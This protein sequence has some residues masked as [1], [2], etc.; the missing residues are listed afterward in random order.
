[1]PK[2]NLIWLALAVVIGALL[3]K[4]PEFIVQQEQLYNRFGPMLDVHAQIRKNYVEEVPDNTLIRGAIDGM[5]GRLDPYSH[6]FDQAELDQFNIRTRGEFKGI[7]IEIVQSETGEPL[8]VSPIEGSPAFEAGLRSGDLITRIDSQPTVEL[9]LAACVRLIQGE[10]GTSVTLGIQRPET[11][12]AFEKSITRGIVKVRTVRG[13]ARDA[14]YDWDYLIDPDRRI[15]YVR[16]TSFE[17]VTPEQFDEVMGALLNRQRMRGLVLDLRDNPGGLLDAVVAIANRFLNDGPIVTIRY[18][19]RPEQPYQANGEHTC[20]DF[21]LVILVNKG[22]ASASEILSGALRDRGRAVLVG[23]R[24]F[25]KGSVQEL[26]DIKGSGGLEGAVKLTIAYYYLP[27]GQ[28][29]HG[30]GVAPDKVVPLSAEQQ[31]TMNESWRQVYVTEGLPSAS[32]PATT[33]APRRRTIMIDPQLQVALDILHEQL[34]T[35]ARPRE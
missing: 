17:Q 32:G 34:D 24:T 4:V 31:E 28:R 23:E 20:P 21:P 19:S 9:S 5:L 35:L 27:K 3:W 16:I 25:G 11:G 10:P 26:I 2:R 33:S 12:Q 22:S 7:G 1:M 14:G 30:I 8:V 15:G 29:I 13:W 18:R 6:Y